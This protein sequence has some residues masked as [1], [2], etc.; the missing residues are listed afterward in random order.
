MSPS[1]GARRD[2]AVSSTTGLLL[3]VAIGALLTAGGTYLLLELGNEDIGGPA[4]TVFEATQ[5][6]ETL[7]IEHTNGDPVA[8]ENLRVVGG[9]V[10]EMPETVGAGRSIEVVP[11]ATVVELHYEDGRVSQQLL[12]T[13][14]ELTRLVVTVENGAGQ[15]LAFRPVG[16]YDLSS[17]P[18][19]SS[20]AELE[21]LLDRTGEPPTPSFVGATDENG[22]FAAATTTRD[23]LERGGEYV[24]VTAATGPATERTYAV[25]RLVLGSGDNTVR[26]V[27]P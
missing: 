6:G 12:S 9:T 18:A 13:E 11:T 15:T 25:G 8:G 2:R 1:S 16:V 19:V 22:E 10:S 5:N 20:A 3:F 4:N 24:V 14:A 17:N 7:V 23:E 21:T 27:L 26:L